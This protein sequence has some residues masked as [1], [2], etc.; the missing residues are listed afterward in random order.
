MNLRTKRFVPIPKHPFDIRAQR[1]MAQAVNAM[2]NRQVIPGSALALHQSDSNEVLVIP[3]PTFETVFPFLLYSIDNVSATDEQIA[4]FTSL[5]TNINDYTVQIR[6][7][8]IGA[9]PYI[10]P[11]ESSGLYGDLALPG[12]G[13]FET[14]LYCPNTD[15]APQ[16]KSISGF[17]P[18]LDYFY[19]PK[20]ANKGTTIIID[21]TQD[22][23]LVGIP[24]SS[25]VG[26]QPVSC[27]QI[28][29]NPE[30]DGFDQFQSS[31]AS[32]WI[33]IVDDLNNGLYPNLMA[34][35]FTLDP[36][37][38]RQS[39]LFPAGNNIIPIGVYII[40]ANLNVT[41][42]LP[43]TP[44]NLYQILGGNLTDRFQAGMTPLRGMWNE[45]F[46]DLPDG[47]TDLNFFPG[48]QVIDDTAEIPFGGGNIYN[49]WQVVAD[50]PFTSKI[51]QSPRDGQWQIAGMVPA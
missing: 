19:Y 15:S 14:L 45:L 47:A 42:Y 16:S 21:N 17:L 7:G 10:S 44:S 4:Q 49:L 2:L 48:D 35:M 31:A 40:G 36:P 30:I 3:Q 25:P 6:S 51:G 5:N 38:A 41:G 12:V 27:D 43:L 50:S 1:E 20:T 46:A 34:R 28:C 22:T 23:L 39:Q 8:I 24:P 11:L 33:E 18:L 26:T 37:T 29:L 9:R 13:N 32:F